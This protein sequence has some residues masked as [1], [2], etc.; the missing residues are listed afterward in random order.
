MSNYT[1][2]AGK[3]IIVGSLLAMP[4][5]KHS[6]GCLRV[7]RVIE[8]IPSKQQQYGGNTPEK[9]RVEWLMHNEYD[10]PRTSIVEKFGNALVLPINF[11]VED[12]FEGRSAD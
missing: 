9:I 2:M 11:P 10:P 8:L 1:D 12:Q 7:G 6:T 5:A 3:Q 4:F